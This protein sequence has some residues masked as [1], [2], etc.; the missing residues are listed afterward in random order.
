MEKWYPHSGLN[1]YHQILRCKSKTSEQLCQGHSY[2]WFLLTSHVQQLQATAVCSRP[3]LLTYWHT[4]HGC[5]W[6]PRGDRP[7][8]C[9]IQCTAQGTTTK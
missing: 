1:D 6:R 4:L 5:T 7:G 9:W 3:L 8:L 2:E